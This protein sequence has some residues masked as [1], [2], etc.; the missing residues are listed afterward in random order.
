MDKI[1]K[2]QWAQRLLQD[3]FFKETMQE[4]KNS[5]VHAIIQTNEH[6]VSDRENLYLRIKFLD[7]FVG[8]LEGMAAET[9]IK[10]KKW[11]IW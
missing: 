8:H 4:L 7:Q 6:Q 1:L 9:L 3:D 11:K 5:Y 2:S 10:E